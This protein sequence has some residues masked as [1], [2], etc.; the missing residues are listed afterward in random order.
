M[1]Y[2]NRLH[3]EIMHSRV[4]DASGAVFVRLQGKRSRA[5]PFVQISRR[6]LAGLHDAMGAISFDNAVE[7]SSGDVRATI[8]SLNES[9]ALRKC[10]L[11]ALREVVSGSPHSVTSSF[12]PSSAS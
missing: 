12:A 5:H 2:E 6:L 1:S 9:C 3:D 11:G 7:L 10:V 4:L 8:T